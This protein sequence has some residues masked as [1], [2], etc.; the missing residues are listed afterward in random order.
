[1]A[2]S[3]SD[4]SDSK[5]AKRQAYVYYTLSKCIG[6]AD[7]VR[8]LGG[9]KAEVPRAVLAGQLK[10]DEAGGTFAQQIASAK[11]FGLVD[12]RGTY[13]LTQLALDYFTPTDEKQR[14]RAKLAMLK[15][16][17][18]YEAL[19]DRFDG[20]RLPPTE[21][22]ANIIQR[23]YDVNESW[24]PRVASLFVNSLRDAGVLDSDGFLRYSAKLHAVGSNGGENPDETRATET[25]DG[26]TTVAADRR[27]AAPSQ[28]AGRT[29]DES[30]PPLGVNSW[31]FRFGGGYVRLDTSDDM[32]LA[33]WNKLNQ[34]VQVLKPSHPE[35]GVE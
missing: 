20:S 23:E 29:R 11:G 14:G 7:A 12:G 31:T 5:T 27:Q 28:P 1:M 16:P 22:L 26:R 25:G 30:P 9:A 15:G 32:P 35:G 8:L 34:Y 19:I 6:V 24:K 3:A 2:K 33:L 10:V 21:T 18:I 4:N 17:S 13:T